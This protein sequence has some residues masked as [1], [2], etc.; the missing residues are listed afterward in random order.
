[1]AV[2]RVEGLVEDERRF[3][4][5]GFDVAIDHSSV[6]LPHRQPLGVCSAVWIFPPNNAAHPGG[7][8]AARAAGG[9]S[10][11]LPSARAT[12]DAW[13]QQSRSGRR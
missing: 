12:G 10:Q 13:T 5:T 11:T 3:L 2:V 1:M 6:A 4:E 9:R 7:L 8:A